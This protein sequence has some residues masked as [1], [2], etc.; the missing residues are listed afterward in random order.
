MAEEEQSY[1]SIC[2]DWRETKREQEEHLY[3]VL[4][5]DLFLL[6]FVSQAQ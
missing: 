6:P 5:S 1:L 4:P 2:K 3:L